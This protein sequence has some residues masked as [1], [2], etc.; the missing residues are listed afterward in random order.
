[1]P[2]LAR[3][4][5]V[6]VLALVALVPLT[7]LALSLYARAA[8]V[9]R[10]PVV[11]ANERLFHSL[12]LPSGA[13]V[14]GSNVYPVPRWGND[15]SLVPTKG[16]RTE[17]FVRLPRRIRERDLLAHYRRALAG[18]RVQGTVFTRGGATVD[19]E[20]FDLRQGRVRNYGLYVSQ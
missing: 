1:V 4:H 2:S 8:S 6:V 16:Y 13:R 14:L 5:T 3:L 10:G 15:G 12:A 19:L 7:P 18:W 9:G 17:F 20:L 11:A